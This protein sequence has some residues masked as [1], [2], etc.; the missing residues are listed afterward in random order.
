MKTA[1]ELLLVL[2]GLA[3]AA[4]CSSGS[5]GESPAGG[6]DADTDADSD[7]DTDADSDTEADADADTDADTDAGELGPYEACESSSECQPDLDCVSG[8]AE[9]LYG[10]CLAECSSN[11]DCPPPP[12]P[13][14]MQVG[15]HP[16]E[17]LCLILCGSYDSECPEWLECVAWEMCLPPSGE[18]AT[19]EFGEECSGAAQCLGEADC[20]EFSSGVGHCYPLC[21]VQQDCDQISPDYTSTCT[22]FGPASICLF[23]CPMGGGPDDCPGD[24]T[25]QFGLCL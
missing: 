4:A 24:L 18:E 5:S 6:A 14:T 23:D 20:V 2:A 22:S 13:E 21:E 11:E 9:A 10:Q 17:G 1:F 7:A 19:Q 12:D 16:E 8:Y 25:C 3:A 15:C